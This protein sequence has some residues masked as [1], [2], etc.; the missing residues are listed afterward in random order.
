MVIVRRD[1][2][3][4]PIPKMCSG[5]ASS[6]GLVVYSFGS[7]QQEILNCPATEEVVLSEDSCLRSFADDAYV[8]ADYKAQGNVNGDLIFSASITYKPIETSDGTNGVPNV[9]SITGDKT[10]PCI[11]DISEC[12]DKSND[13]NP[14][15]IL[16]PNSISININN[17]G[18]ATLSFVLTSKDKFGSEL[19][20]FSLPMGSNSRF[21]GYVINIQSEPLSGTDYY[22][23][24]IT[25]IGEII[26]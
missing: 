21:K 7:S 14:N 4:K 20:H 6:N 16:D 13:K 2:V 3:G 12:L 26:K 18:L 23:H 25:A 9:K 22:E 19:G 10:N 5:N 15:K 24:R 1:R 17:Q 8:S 11:N